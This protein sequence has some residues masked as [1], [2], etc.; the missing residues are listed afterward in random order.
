MS[1]ERRRTTFEYFALR[2]V[3]RADREEFVN[4]GLVLFAPGDTSAD[5]FLAA[6]SHVR[7]EPLRALCPAIDLEAVAAALAT[8]D[9]V[10]RGDA[11]AGPAAGSRAYDRFRWLAAPRSTVVRPGPVHGGLT[12]DPGRQ[13]AHLFACLAG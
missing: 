1:G 6:A 4:V 11:T 2:C 8:I 9:A 7:G 5:D 12:A 10:C 13:L 3:P